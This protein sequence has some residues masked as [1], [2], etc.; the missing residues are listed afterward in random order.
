M[1]RMSTLDERAAIRFQLALPGLPALTVG[2]SQ[3]KTDIGDWTKFWMQRFAPLFYVHVQQDFVLEGGGSGASWAPL[4]PAYAQWK[5]SRFPGRGILVRS[6]ALKA[7][8]SG[9]EAPRSVF[10][11]GPTSLDI[12]TR[13]PYALH[14]QV[15]SSRMPQ[16]PPLRVSPAFMRAVGLHMRSH[17]Q[18]AWV[19]RR[20]AFIADVRAGL[21][22]R[23]R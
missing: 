10:R 11:P 17:I 14:H 7:S 13:V 5:A 22:E 15:G 21:S 9:P 4:S 19:E 2:L 18:E 6:G 8:L 12:G 16:R 1:V 3:L 23:L 20:T